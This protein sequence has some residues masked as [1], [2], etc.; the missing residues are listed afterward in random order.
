MDT[1][2][3]IHTS[4]LP[5]EKH[6]RYLLIVDDTHVLNFE[7]KNVIDVNELLDI[8]TTLIWSKK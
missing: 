8:K 3:E 6:P 4:M 5:K 7:Y 2:C 1:K